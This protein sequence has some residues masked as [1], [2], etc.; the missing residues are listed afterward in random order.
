M[1]KAL[2][3]L[4]AIDLLRHKDNYPAFA[5]DKEGCFYNGQVGNCGVKCPCLLLG[6][7]PEEAEILK[8][9]E[10]GRD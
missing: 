8:G 6:K 1:S 7:C 10:H 9:A 5:T 2:Q 4:A 3:C